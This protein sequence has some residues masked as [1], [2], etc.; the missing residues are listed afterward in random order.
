MR[1]KKPKRLR[2]GD[3]VAVLSPSWGGPSLCPHVYENG[4]KVLREWGLAVQVPQRESKCR[5]PERESSLSRERYQR[6]LSEPD[7]QG[8]HCLH[9]WG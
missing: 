5:F 2:E 4:L 3:V 1:Y 6:R 8:D 7:G 9:W